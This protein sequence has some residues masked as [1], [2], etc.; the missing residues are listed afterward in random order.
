M[1]AAETCNN[2]D[3]LGFLA[4]FLMLNFL[5]HPGGCPPASSKDLHLSALFGP[6][7]HLCTSLSSLSLLNDLLAPKF[8]GYW[9]EGHE[10]YCSTS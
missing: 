8:Q 7:E 3:T 10:Y 5:A 1:K 9:I 2:Q 6:F 4:T